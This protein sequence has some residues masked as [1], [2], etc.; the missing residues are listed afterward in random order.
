[1][2]RRLR[3]SRIAADD[4]DEIAEYIARDSR[5]YA[6][7]FVTRIREVP[8]PPRPE[9]R[10]A[11]AQEG[12]LCALSQGMRPSAVPPGRRAR[13][14]ENLTIQRHESLEKRLISGHEN[15]D[16]EVSDHGR[17]EQ[18]KRGD[19]SLGLVEIELCVKIRAVEPLNELGV[20]RAQLTLRVDSI[21]PTRDVNPDPPLLTI[22][23]CVNM[24]AGRVDERRNQVHFHSGS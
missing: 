10:L 19:Q 13:P 2:A 3:W 16:L 4:L 20:R 14:S 21:R 23:D 15:P 17:A 12:R 22:S 9:P 24:P 6:A 18:I 1:M 11:L 7:S 8:S 5:T